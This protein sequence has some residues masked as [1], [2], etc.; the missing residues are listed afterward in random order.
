MRLR[1]AIAL[2]PEPQRVARP[3]PRRAAHPICTVRSGA[4]AISA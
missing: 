1:Y 4:L 2:R 3:P